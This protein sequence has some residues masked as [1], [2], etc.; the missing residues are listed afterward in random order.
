MTSVYRHIVNDKVPKLIAKLYQLRLIQFFQ[1][2]RT[3]DLSQELS[4]GDQHRVLLVNE[5]ITII[6]GT[7]FHAPLL[8]PRYVANS[9]E[10]EGFWVNQS[11]KL[12]FLCTPRFLK[13]YK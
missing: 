10:I 4:G 13:D 7:C 1:V 11:S 2:F 12:L 9:R 3:I 6:Q 5:V 8:T